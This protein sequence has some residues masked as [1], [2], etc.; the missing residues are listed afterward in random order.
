MNPD[1]PHILVADDQPTVLLVLEAMLEDHYQVHAFE[2]GGPLMA[3]VNAGGRVDI[4]LTDVMMPGLDGFDLCRQL[5]AH[6]VTRGIPILFLTGLDRDA[7]ETFGL[8][9]GAEDFIHKPFSPAVVLARVRAHL[10]LAQ[11]RQE[12]T[13]RNEELERVVQERTREIVRRR[14]QLIAA[15]EATITALCTLAEVRDNETGNHILRTQHY[16]RLL[17]EELL[18]HPRFRSSLSDD[19]VRAI[20]KSA[21]LH[22]VGKVAIPDAILLKPGKLDTAEWA[23]MR[24][25]C[26]YGRDAIVKAAGTLNGDESPFLNFAAEIAYS[27]HERWDGSGYPQ[28]LA[29]EAIP[30]SARLMAVAD[31]YD[32]L[33]SR[34]VYKPAFSHEQA[35]A[36]ITTERGTQFDPDIIDAFSN[37]TDLFAHIARNYGDATQA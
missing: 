24:R 11:A 37:L 16:V 1:R 25:H 32:A 7:D 29:G 28:G 12:L 20:F 10:A 3:Y 30:L 14:E 6:P 19:R 33:I 4:V 9:L 22:D 21:P 27:H 13:Q 2:D 15:Q 36:M 34:R 8:S 18:E 17:G 26:E 23:I 5:K 35:V 31:V